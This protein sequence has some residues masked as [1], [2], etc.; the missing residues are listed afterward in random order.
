MAGDPDSKIWFTMMNFEIQ[1]PKLN[2]GE[3]TVPLTSVS[4]GEF[5]YKIEVMIA[6][7]LSPNAVTYVKFK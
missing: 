2:D 6:P 4:R 1:E 3:R 5:K 7:A